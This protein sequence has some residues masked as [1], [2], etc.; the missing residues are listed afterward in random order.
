MSVAAVVGAWQL[1]VA[2]GVVDRRY[3][4][5]PSLIFPTMIRLITDGSI[6]PHVASTMEKIG[7]GFGISILLGVPLGLL[8]GSWRQAEWVIAPVVETVRSVPTLALLPAFMLLFGIGFKFPVVVVVWVAWT[9]IF[10]AA[11]SGVRSVPAEITEAAT[12]DRASRFQIALSIVF[13]LAGPSILTGMRVAMANAFVVI[14]VAEMMGQPIGLGFYIY[15]AAQTFHVPE[16]YAA[17]VLLGSIA[18]ATN[19]LLVAAARIIWR[20]RV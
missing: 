18:W 17:I 2:V 9:P 1:L 4:S 10:L 15:N 3:L 8:C 5:P 7:V 11:I 16:M 12:I 14:V 20:S 13:P 6:L 19:T